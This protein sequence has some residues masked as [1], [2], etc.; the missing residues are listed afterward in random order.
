MYKIIVDDYFPYYPK[1]ARPAFSQSK[2]NELWVL[3]L[4]KAWAKVNGNYENT[5]KGY[6]SEAFRALTGSPSLF[7]KHDYVDSIW[8]IV[9]DADR[10]NFIICGSAARGE[11]NKQEFDK[12]GLISDHAYAVISC[13][14]V[15]VNKG[16]N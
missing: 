12:L 4:E 3:L 16:K 2:D 13:H 14:E 1:K 5:I 9:L 10:K 11:L 8:D 6:V 15:T 7:Y